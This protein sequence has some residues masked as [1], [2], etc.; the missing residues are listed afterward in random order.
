MIILK[1][2]TLHNRR[3]EKKVKSLIKSHWAID[4]VVDLVLLIGGLWLAYE[5]IAGLIKCIKRA[6]GP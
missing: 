5:S 1:I 2:S 4:Y 6:I 3:K